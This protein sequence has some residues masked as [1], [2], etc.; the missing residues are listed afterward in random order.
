[1]F[2]AWCVDEDELDESPMVKMRPP[3]VPEQPVAVLDAA[4]LKALFAT[5]GGKDFADRRDHAI[6]RLFADTGMR[7]SELAGLSLA[8]VDLDDQRALVLGKGRRPRACPFGAKTTQALDRY[9]R[10]RSGHKLHDLP[11]LWLGPANRQPMT[12]NGIAQ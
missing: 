11:Q 4:E 9:V 10:T 2:F 3:V 5:C 12:P 7:L 1:Q 6:L 8:D